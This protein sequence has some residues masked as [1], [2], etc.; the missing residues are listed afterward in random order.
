M[1]DL[2][3]KSRELG[4]QAV[5]KAVEV[6]AVSEAQ[7]KCSLEALELEN[8][9]RIRSTMCIFLVWALG[10]S[11]VCCFGL[12]LLNGFHP[13]EFHIEGALLKWL[14]GATIAQI[15]LLLGVFARAV[16]R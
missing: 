1:T 9:L 7:T 12:I 13:W 8:R 2:Q 14:C 6:E 16:W 3:E 10:F 4:I 5:V 11:T 15:A